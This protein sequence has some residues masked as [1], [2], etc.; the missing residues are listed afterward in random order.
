MLP[1]GSMPQTA[2]GIGA[3]ILRRPSD[4]QVAYTTVGGQPASAVS[5]AMPTG[6]RSCNF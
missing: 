1:E 5:M 2:F 6:V 4:C 3:D